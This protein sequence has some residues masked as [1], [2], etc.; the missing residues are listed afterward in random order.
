MPGAGN[1]SELDERDGTA[2]GAT[3]DNCISVWVVEATS[4]E[5]FAGKDDVN[6]AGGS[7]IANLRARSLLDANRRRKIRL[8]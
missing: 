2:N 5:V 4:A 8:Q 1:V 7:V 6:S 3:D